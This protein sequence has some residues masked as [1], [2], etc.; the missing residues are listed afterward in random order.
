MSVKIHRDIERK[1]KME[2][3]ELHLLENDISLKLD[4]DKSAVFTFI[5]IPHT[6]PWT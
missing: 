4:R 3:I 5:L 2:A 1:D 6:I